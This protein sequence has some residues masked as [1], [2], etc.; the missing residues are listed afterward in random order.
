[1]RYNTN[2]QWFKRV[3]ANLRQALLHRKN[4]KTYLTAASRAELREDR[5]NF[6][7]LAL[8][9]RSSR[10]ISLRT[11]AEYFEDTKKDYAA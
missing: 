11:A 7:N 5:L 3:R 10:A 4:E 9:S 1:M 8:Q 2:S 6:Y